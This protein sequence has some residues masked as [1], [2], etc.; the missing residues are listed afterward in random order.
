METNHITPLFFLTLA[1]LFFV[2]MV[3]AFWILI[4]YI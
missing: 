4:P 2:L 3:S 1:K